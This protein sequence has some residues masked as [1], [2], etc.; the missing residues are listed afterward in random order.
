MRC[1]RSSGVFLKRSIIGSFHDLCQYSREIIFYF[2]VRKTQYLKAA[3]FQYPVSLCIV[4]CL[5]LMD[6]SVQFHH[7]PRQVAIE[8]SDE[9]INNLLTP[10]MQTVQAACPQ[11]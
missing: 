9:P 11:A 8:V 10:E 5:L 6:R 4:I 1:G 7:K 2:P 3:L